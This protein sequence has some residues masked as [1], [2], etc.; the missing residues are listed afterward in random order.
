MLSS[1][2]RLDSQHTDKRIVLQ[3]MAM[4]N[5]GLDIRNRTW[6]KISIP[7]SFLGSQLVEWLMEH[8]DGLGERKDAK[9]YASELLKEKLIAHVVNKTT[10]SEQCY[11]VF[12]EQMTGRC[13][14]I[15]LSHY[16]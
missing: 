5:S 11:Y 13:L 10:F 14:P 4:P 16:L 9:K 8:V 1:R 3:A 15:P 2:Q 12:G 6:L 7:S